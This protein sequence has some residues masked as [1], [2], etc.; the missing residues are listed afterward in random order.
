M[1]QFQTKSQLM[2]SSEI[3]RSLVRL[4]HEII[5]KT[6]DPG[7][8]VV[9]GIRRRGAV[10][11]ERL[12]EKLEALAGHPF[13]LGVLDITLYKDD[14]STVADHP[15]LNGTNIPFSLDGKTVILVD[16]VLYTGRT[17]LAAL[18]ALFDLG[19]P[20]SVKLCVLIDR[21]R[22]ELPMQ[23]DYVGRQLE[24]T[25]NEI[26]EVKVDPIDGEERV[27]LVEKVAE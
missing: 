26:I 11:A 4:A 14:L 7:E 5:E 13:P 22:R 6:Q 23:P 17:T 27:L 24:T 8:A 25:E 10:L 21:G 20:A 3:D 12:A 18:R 2:N 1:S 9:I 19:S 16:D 15:V